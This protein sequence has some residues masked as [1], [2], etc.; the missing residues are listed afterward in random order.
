M[1][2]VMARAVLAT[3]LM[4]TAAVVKELVREGDGGKVLID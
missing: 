1:V 3:V 4:V 2:F